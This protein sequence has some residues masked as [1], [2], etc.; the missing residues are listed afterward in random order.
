MF[1]VGTLCLPRT[2]QEFLPNFE[3]SAQKPPATRFYDLK[4]RNNAIIVKIVESEVDFR[5][6]HA[7]QR[8]DES[9]CVALSFLNLFWNLL[10][11]GYLFLKDTGTRLTSVK[12]SAQSVP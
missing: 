8:P 4:R 9:C 2:Y 5:V 6:L 11:N 10:M 7:Q 3:F 12:V 1:R